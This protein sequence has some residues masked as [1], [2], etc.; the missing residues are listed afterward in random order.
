MSLRLEPHRGC[1][2]TVSADLRVRMVGAGHC[3]S[4]RTSLM[5]MFFAPNCLSMLSEVK[6]GGSSSL[7]IRACPVSRSVRLNAL[8]VKKMLGVSS[9][10]CRQVKTRQGSRS[11]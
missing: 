4:K 9:T 5:G 3:F 10:V 8:Q 2:G 1:L 7:G 6:A 11:R